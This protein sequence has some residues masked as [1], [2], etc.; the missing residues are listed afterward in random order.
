MDSRKS[1]NMCRSRSAQSLKMITCDQ[2]N[3]DDKLSILSQMF[4]VA[5]SL[6]ESDYEHEFCL[7]IRLLTRVRN[8]SVSSA[9]QGMKL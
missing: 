8:D 4:W 7:A 1:T 9:D 3:Q 5:V 2:G 6:L